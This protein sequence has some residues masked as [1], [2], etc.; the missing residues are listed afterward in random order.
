MSLSSPP[1]LPPCVGGS[2]TPHPGLTS[3][4]ACRGSPFL[5]SGHQRGGWAPADGSPRRSQGLTPLQGCRCR[6]FPSRCLI[7]KPLSSVQRHLGESTWRGSSAD[8]ANSG[9]AA[10]QSSPVSRAG[11]GRGNPETPRP[12]TAA[13]AP[14]CLSLP[15]ASSLWTESLSPG[16]GSGL[17]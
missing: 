15:G 10:G 2:R 4:L 3:F 16:E 11:Y 8:A 17:S 12:A 14:W 13:P 1:A 5:F 6:F 7:H 9:Q